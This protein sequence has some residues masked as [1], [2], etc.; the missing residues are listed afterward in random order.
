MKTKYFLFILIALGLT[1][2]AEAQFLKK[3]KKKAEKAAER[4]V[5]RKTEELVTNK[6]EKTKAIISSKPLR[7]SSACT[8]LSNSS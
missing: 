7:R 1:F 6:T 5:L 2:N 3:L 4:T 8:R